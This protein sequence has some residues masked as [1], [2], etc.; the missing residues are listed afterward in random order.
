V[1]DLVNT[2][3]G[4]LAVAV[5]LD[6]VIVA[7]FAAGSLAYDGRLA[8]M[9]GFSANQYL[10]IMG[11][12]SLGVA[13]ASRRGDMFGDYPGLVLVSAAVLAVAAVY[14]PAA[15]YGFRKWYQF[16][17]FGLLG[18]A[19]CVRIRGSRGGQWLPLLLFGGVGLLLGV[20]GL[21]QYVRSGGGHRLAIAGGGPI[22]F[23][24]WVGMAI[25]VFGGWLV[26]HHRRWFAVI[27]PI[28]IPVALGLLLVLL[29]AGSKGPVL[30]FVIAA[31]YLLRG[32]SIRWS[33]SRR[34]LVGGLLLLGV[35]GTIMLVDP[36]IFTRFLLTPTEAS[37]RGSWWIRFAWLREAVRLIDEQPWYGGGLGSWA[38]TMFHA[39]EKFYP[40]NLIAELLVEAGPVLGGG[41]I[42]LWLW[43]AGRWWR[44]VAATAP[45]APV[46]KAL[47][48]YWSVNVLFSGDLTDSR[49]LVLSVGFL[50]A[51]TGTTRGAP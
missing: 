15:E 24:R 50:W 47:V 42:V 28:A 32:F 26:L 40:H 38:T 12:G 18:A 19:W 41:L 14:S 27:S 51:A 4:H 23:A 3:I 44:S 25:I 1:R 22:V 7:V 10:A 29:L 31:A 37:S 35:L 34:V 43:R 9:P 5:A 17:G 33:V 36:A 45:A 49:N 13:A 11:L 8:L 48:L 6:I 2:V 46:I 39:D 30:S 16:L 21:V 20:G